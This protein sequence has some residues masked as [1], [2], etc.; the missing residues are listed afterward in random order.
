VTH[1]KAERGPAGFDEINRTKT[2]GNFGWPFLIADNKPYRQHDFAT[3]ASGP[4]QDPAHPLNRSPLNT[5]PQDLPEGRPAWIFYPYTPSARFPTVGSG[6]RTAC[7]G[8]FYRL[9]PGLASTRKLP[10]TFDQSQLI[11]DWERRWILAVGVHPDGSPGSM[12]RV[13][14]EIE[15]KRPIEMELGPDGALYVIE[16]GSGWENN[17]DAQLVRIQT[18]TVR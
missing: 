4:A 15:L 12:Q 5:G 1:A 14:P 3:G 13:A 8:P 9:D 10:E 6:G 17:K 2:A 16:F 7:A 18:A 11:Y